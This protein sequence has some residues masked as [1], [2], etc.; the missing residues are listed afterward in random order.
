MSAPLTGTSEIVQMHTFAADQRVH[1]R[2]NHSQL[3]LYAGLYHMGRGQTWSQSPDIA[4]DVQPQ[5]HFHGQH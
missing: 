5:E 3:G 4:T 2:D 1:L